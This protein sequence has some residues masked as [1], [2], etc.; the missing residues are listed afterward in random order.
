MLGTVALV[1]DLSSRVTVSSIGISHE[2]THFLMQWRTLLGRAP[3]VLH[4]GN[5]ANNA[6]H[7]ARLMEL[8]GIESVVLALKDY[9]V[10]STPEW[11]EAD[12]KDSPSDLF[13]PDWAETGLGGYQ[14]PDWFISGP[15]SESVRY[16]LARSGC[17]DSDAQELYR[18]LIVMAKLIGQ[19]S[20]LDFGTPYRKPW[21]HQFFRRASRRLRMEIEYRV[22]SLL[23]DLLKFYRRQNPSSDLPGWFPWRTLKGA[24]DNRAKTV[25]GD[26]LRR[27]DFVWASG[28]MESWRLLFA[29]FDLVIGYSTYGLY[30]LMAETPFIAFEHGTIRE[31]PFQP[32]AEGRTT[33][34]TYAMADHVLVTN[35]DCIPKADI[36]CPGRYTFINHPYHQ[37]H[38]QPV[39]GVE[40]LRAS[41]CQELDA[42]FLLFFPT[43]Q[44]WVPAEGFAD[45]GNDVLIQAAARV[46]SGGLRLGLI[47]C[48]WG[49]NVAQSRRLVQELGL[50]PHVR[51]MPPVGAIAFNRHCQAVDLVAD[52]FT[53]GAFGGVLFKAMCNRAPVIT[54]IDEDKL[55]QAYPVVPPVFNGRTV[56]EL[57]QLLRQAAA[58]PMALKE[59]GVAGRQ[60]IE[61]HHNGME[62]LDRQIK[63]FAKVLRQR[64]TQSAPRV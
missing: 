22:M 49:R 8:V 34:L 50:T 48:E 58:D 28:S 59:R 2:A 20:R 1:F 53:L 17:G 45:K 3:K 62:T 52:Q 63:V 35:F 36:I 7:N 39:S 44:D 14:R 10:M 47:M 57:V 56:G 19:D 18:S 13:Y 37:D 23:Q 41:L 31:I 4:L 32:G 6:F 38:A 29:K 27:K 46:R 54:F 9:F 33:F 42:G 30:P 24:Y 26:N 15:V 12:L 64:Q 16:A 61:Q 55:R 60:W 40:E 5:V 11:E 21:N 43:R 51:W 25:R